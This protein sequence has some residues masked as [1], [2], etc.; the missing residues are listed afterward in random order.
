CLGIGQHLALGRNQRAQRSR[1][2]GGRTLVCRRTQI[3]PPFASSV[4]QARKCSSSAEGTIPYSVGPKPCRITALCLVGAWA[5]ESSERYARSGY[6]RDL[7]GETG[8]R[9]FL[10][11]SGCCRVHGLRGAFWLNPQ[12]PPLLGPELRDRCLSIGLT[13]D[14]DNEEENREPIQPTT[15]CN[16]IPVRH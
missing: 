9:C 3:R 2:Y 7:G 15:L 6:T 11:A 4:R 12:K 16:Q 14:S 13:S 1:F 8:E 5:G 10:H